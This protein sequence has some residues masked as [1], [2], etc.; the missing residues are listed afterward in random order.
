MVWTQL[1]NRLSSLPLII[2]GPILRRTEPESITVWVALR[3]P[4]IVTLRVYSET[5]SSDL[6][7]RAI[8]T[9][10][11]VG[12][13][14]NLHIVA[15][16]AQPTESDKKLISGENYYYNLFFDEINIGLTF[17]AEGALNLRSDGVTDAHGTPKTKLYYADPPEQLQLPTFSLPPEDLDSLRILHGSCRKLHNEGRDAMPGIDDI[18]DFDWHDPNK[19]P[20]MLFLTGDQI[21]A[22]DISDTVLYLLDDASDALL[23]WSE[24][25]PGIDQNDE[26]LLPGK[27]KDIVEK[28]ECG[29]TTEDGESHLLRLGEFYSAYLFAWSDVLWPKNQNFPDLEMVH[30]KPPRKPFRHNDGT[31][32]THDEYKAYNEYQE[33]K[34]KMKDEIVKDPNKKEKPYLLELK[35]GLHK[36]RRALA[37]IPTYMIFDDHDVTDDWNMTR[38]WCERTLKKRLGHRVTQNAL[39]AYA[40][41]QSWGNTPEQFAENGNSPGEALLTAAQDW[42]FSSGQDD[43]AEK[44]ITD[45]LGLPQFGSNIFTEDIN[46][47]KILIRSEGALKWHYTIKWPKF[48]VIVLDTRTRHSYPGSK[49]SPASLLSTSAF[50]DQIDEDQQDSGILVTFVVAS[51]PIITFPFFKTFWFWLFAL[52]GLLK[53][54]INFLPE[55]VSLGSLWKKNH[56]ELDLPDHWQNQ[57]KPFELLIAKLAL[58]ASAKNGKRESRVII[59]TGDVHF[60][61]SSRLQYSANK[62]FTEN[63]SI[64]TIPTQAVFAHFSASSFKKQDKKTKYLHS[65]GYK[66]NDGH[67]ALY[68]ILPWKTEILS[69]IPVLSKIVEWSDRDPGSTYCYG[70]KKTIQ[71]SGKIEPLVYITGSLAWWLSDAL[72]FFWDALKFKHETG[73]SLTPKPDWA[74]RIDFILADNELRGASPFQ[75]RELHLPNFEED[76]VEALVNYIAMSKNHEDYARKWGHGKEIIGV[77]NFC[78]ISFDWKEEGE[79]TVFNKSW[80]RLK[81]K[82]N[83]EDFLR[84]FPLSKF[85]VS[86]DFEDS[87]YEIP[88]LND[89]NTLIDD[90]PI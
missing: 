85:S 30:G 46:G 52:N 31:L 78:E 41:F 83:N 48:E 27:R 77:N 22:D 5:V 50:K 51:T 73:S 32:P 64:P 62:P 37:N 79:K 89:L 76:R 25:L 56:Y 45:L 14:M 3:E 86:L 90:E 68:H 21:Y 8:G 28:K 11:T 6:T 87:R 20:H 63:S 9:R 61:S 67:F 74:Y 53:P 43:K 39:L 29:F 18:L 60:S 66:F 4:R 80:W 75:P 72:K 15:V 2:C 58:R 40:V 82:S 42:Y 88:N 36:V 12:L 1:K 57:E 44:Q 33:N 38:D 84:V 26:S 49:F 17:V 13:G 55:L 23:G 70:W 16:T 59:L 71:E 54:A 10:K 69:N 19:R 24:I 34:K 81:R 7:L 35:E 47:E 65:H